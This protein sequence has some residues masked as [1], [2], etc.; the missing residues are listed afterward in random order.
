MA[1]EVQVLSLQTLGTFEIKGL[2]K[3]NIW[4]LKRVKHGSLFRSQKVKQYFHFCPT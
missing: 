2:L 3:S 4:N 1:F